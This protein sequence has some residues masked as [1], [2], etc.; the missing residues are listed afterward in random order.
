M[1]TK[2]QAV[3]G[4]TLLQARWLNK[5]FGEVDSASAGS[6]SFTIGSEGA[7]INVAVALEDGA[8][9]ALASL[10]GV[11]IF[12]SDAAT[13]IGITATAPDGGI[14]IG[15]DGAIID[16]AVAGKALWVQT[17]ADGTF[18]IDITETG[19][20]TF[21]LVVQLPNG[22]QVVSDAIVFLA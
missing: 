3:S 2:T 6:A 21:Y 7:A 11:N 5:L 12:L 20:A 4:W 13:G 8:G 10:Q 1:I 18:D 14:A 15:T 16:A 9:N 17:E 19:A 22:K